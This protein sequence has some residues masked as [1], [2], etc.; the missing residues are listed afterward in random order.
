MIIKDYL[1]T[2]VSPSM[3][4]TSSVPGRP[5]FLEGISII[6]MCEPIHGDLPVDFYWLS[7]HGIQMRNRNQIYIQLTSDAYFGTYTCTG[8]NTF[9]MHRTTFLV[10]K[11][12]TY[13]MLYSNRLL[14]F[15]HAEHNT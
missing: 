3:S 14:P 5:A 10:E 15:I 7:P 2:I 12:G 6:L 8:S 9:G 4:I 1:F 13:K 11:A